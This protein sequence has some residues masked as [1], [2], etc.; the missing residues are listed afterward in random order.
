MGKSRGGKCFIWFLCF[1]P[2]IVARADSSCL[3]IDL[4]QYQPQSFVWENGVPK[5]L[6][7]QNKLCDLISNKSHNKI[8][9]RSN[10][11]SFGDS[12]EIGFCDARPSSTNGHYAYVERSGAV[13][14][15]Y[16]DCSFQNESIQ[17]K[18]HRIYGQRGDPI[19][20]WEWS[21]E[22]SLKNIAF[23]GNYFNKSSS[24]PPLRGTIDAV[25]Y[26][27]FL[28]DLLH[29]HNDWCQQNTKMTDPLLKAT[30]NHVTRRK[31]SSFEERTR[32]MSTELILQSWERLTMPWCDAAMLR[33]WQRSYLQD[34]HAILKAFPNA[35]LFLR[36]QPI[37]SAVFLGNFRC[38]KPMNDYIAHIV[39]SFE[40]ARG[41]N[42]LRTRINPLEGRVVRLIDLYSLFA[43]PN[44]NG[45]GHFAVDN[46]HLTPEG[47]KNYRSFIL[48]VL[49]DYFHYK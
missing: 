38:H 12:Y 17:Y 3:G 7:S 14:G 29:A 30:C 24:T 22:T 18:F 2:L 33:Q 35:A 36:T 45:V 46:I 26:G 41:T 19:G 49:G 5:F 6:N 11:L 10:V 28:W 8:G 23:M 32:E 9:F 40:A 37:S 20:T 21:N 43:A 1:T 34:V 47:F 42:S 31:L 48:S 4:S 27:S 13:I 44:D 15:I 39:R 25:V 16:A